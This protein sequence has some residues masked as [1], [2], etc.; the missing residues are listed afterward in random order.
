MVFGSSEM[1]VSRLRMCCE[2]KWYT[3]ILK[4]AFILRLSQ[5]SWMLSDSIYEA[6]K[7]VTVT[8]WG[9]ILGNMTIPKARR[10]SHG[11]DWK[12]TGYLRVGLLE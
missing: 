2:V 8:E 1:L 12:E 7:R 10:A 11:V 9:T 6:S 3:R 4:A 5:M